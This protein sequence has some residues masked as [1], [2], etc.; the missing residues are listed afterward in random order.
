[1]SNRRTRRIDVGGLLSY[2]SGKVF[3][4]LVHFDDSAWVSMDF[5]ENGFSG[6]L[7]S[8][9]D[10]HGVLIASHLV[11]FEAFHAF[12]IDFAS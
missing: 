12:A 10:L 7:G 2:L 8:S 6:S 1:M 5:L 9:I 3:S 4:V 11:H